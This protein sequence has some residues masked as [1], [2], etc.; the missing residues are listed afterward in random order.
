MIPTATTPNNNKLC[1]KPPRAVEELK[2]ELPNAATAD[3]KPDSGAR[4]SPPFGDA[5]A[6]RSCSSAFR[7]SGADHPRAGDAFVVAP[8]PRV[9]GPGSRGSTVAA[10]APAPC[11]GDGARPSTGATDTLARTDGNSTCTASTGN[12]TGNSGSTIGATIAVTGSGRLMRR[13]ISVVSTLIS[14][15]SR[16]SDAPSAESSVGA[17]SAGGDSSVVVEEE[18]DGA[19]LSCA[20]ALCSDAGASLVCVSEDCACAGEVLSKSRSAAAARPRRN[21]KPTRMATLVV[22]AA[23]SRSMPCLAAPGRRSKVSGVSTQAR[24][25][26]KRNQRHGWSDSRLFGRNSSSGPEVGE[27]PFRR[28][29]PAT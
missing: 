15:V 1:P 9:G 21:R 8:L 29:I 13:S 2:T 20:G 4:A 18:D 12:T 23:A 17:G 26:D 5:L 14:A 24:V 11:E 7:E 19:E 16:E 27:S 6:A 10:G 25:S 28:Q 22:L 3:G